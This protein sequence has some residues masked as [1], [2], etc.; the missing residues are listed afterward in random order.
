[1][2]G[3][4]SLSAATRSNLLSLQ[5]ASKDMNRTQEVL[6]S[7][8]KVNSAIDNPSSYYTARSLDNRAQDLESLLD[9]MGQKIQS[10][11]AALEGI[12]AA[13]RY[14]ELMSSVAT[15]ALDENELSTYVSKI[16]PEAYDGKSNT[17]AIIEEIGDGALA[18]KASDEFYVVS[19]DEDWYLPSM[20]ELMELYGVDIANMEQGIGG[21]GK[22]G[23]NIGKINT[24]LQ[25]LQSLGLATK[26]AGYYW[27]STEA[28]EDEVWRMNMASSADR[29]IIEK[30][31]ADGTHVRA[32]R[33]I[34]NIYNPAKSTA[35]AP[36][37][38]DIVYS[39][40]SWTDTDHYD[41]N[42]TVIGVITHVS[43]DGRDVT[44]M[45]LKDL[46]FSTGGAFDASHPYTNDTDSVT[47]ST[48]IASHVNIEGLEN[49]NSNA[50]KATLQEIETEGTRYT[51]P[52][53]AESIYQTQFNDLLAQ[54]DALIEDSG[55]QG[56]NLLAGDKLEVTFN[57]AGDHKLT[58]QGKD[59]SS[60][61]IGLNKANWESLEDIQVSIKELQSVVSE[62]RAF[63]SDLGNNN[64][65]IQ[66]RQGFTQNLIN[67]LEE[68]ADKLTLADMNEASAS[69]LA[70][71]TRQQLAINA[72][73]LANQSE[74]GVLKL[75]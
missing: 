42:K 9:S 64:S 63:S 52:D 7:N 13:T 54:Y 18:A 50:W 45:N 17:D 36:V 62:L 33:L 71:Q 14:I 61:V 38:G 60:S 2:S 24:T 4:I 65:I 73:S 23:T 29:N 11:S 67:V 6:S 53:K 37:I 75:F 44:I 20:G 5:Q 46:K 39:D 59:I 69:Y 57:E 48:P 74:Q 49:Y 8:Q 51:M 41:E 34:E 1:M 35:T 19:E 72:L 27:S 22:T 21:S 56:I 10:I 66:I 31:I 25:D 40:L 26:L 32:F 43:D 47:W 58:I 68:G 70:L 12:E 30:N 3:R 15:Q 55:Y 16:V 28:D